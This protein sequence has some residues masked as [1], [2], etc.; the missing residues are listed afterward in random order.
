MKV[1][2]IL[3]LTIAAGLA[4]DKEQ[5]PTTQKEST[6]EA[7]DDT[8]RIKIH[9]RITFRIVE[10]HDKTLYLIVHGDGSIICPHIGH[11]SAA[12][13]TPKGLAY[14]AKSDL[15][16]K[17]FEKATVLVTLEG[18]AKLVFKDPGLPCV[19]IFGDIGRQGKYELVEGE[20]LTLTGL[21]LRAGG[22]GFR[23]PKKAEII[24]KS[25][26]GKTT[27]TVNVQEMWQKADLS[28]DPILQDG[29]VVIIP[30]GITV[31]F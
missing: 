3:A 30:A 14:A 25:A 19:A 5:A 4:A 10:D 22:S 6:M 11:L 24:R 2:L 20:T 13:K 8:H 15:E 9:D 16:K 27:I 29:D 17:Y 31:S 1:L 21:I 18:P 28:K 12:G 23:A 7:L 26:E